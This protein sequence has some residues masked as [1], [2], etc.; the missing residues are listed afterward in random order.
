M[1]GYFIYTLFYLFFN[2]RPF[3]LISNNNKARKAGTKNVA[4]MAVIFSFQILGDLGAAGISD[5]QV[6][7]PSETSPVPRKMALVA[8]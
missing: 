1:G 3:P 4:L 2:G 8:S 7:H 5:V 6:K